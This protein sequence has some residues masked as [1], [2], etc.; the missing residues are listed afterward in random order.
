MKLKNTLLIVFALMTTLIAANA[1]NIPIT[2]LPFNI[3]AQGTYVLK[4]NMSYLATNDIPAITIANNINGTVI[5][6]LKGFTITGG[7]ES[8]NGVSFG[9]TIGNINTPVANLYPITVRNGSLIN[10]TVG[11]DCSQGG[12]DNLTNLTFDNLTIDHPLGA[13]VQTTGIYFVATSSTVNNCNLSNYEFGIILNRTGVANN[14]YKANQFTFVTSPFYVENN[15]LST[16]P[17]VLTIPA[18]IQHL[19]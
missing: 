16:D 13:G 6:D 17:V 1:A 12:H 14:S 5:V 11:I 9:V 18:V 8:Q 2:S 4:G 15:N 19:Q 7:G 10:F 3:T